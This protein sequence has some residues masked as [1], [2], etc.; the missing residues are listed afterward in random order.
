MLKAAANLNQQWSALIVEELTRQGI[1]TF[2]I[3]PGSRST[4]LTF[5]AAENPRANTHIIF[6]ER[7][8]AFFALGYARATALPAVLI[9]TSGTAAANYFPAVI[10]ASSENLPLIILSADRPPELK[11]SAANQTIDQTKLF[12]GYARWFFEM[13][14]PDEKIEATFVLSTINYALQK[15]LGQNAGPV[16]LNC[17]FREPL[18]PEPQP[19]DPDYLSPLQEWSKSNGPFTEITTGTP[20]TSLS[21]KPMSEIDLGNSIILC[22]RVNQDEA[23]AITKLASDFNLPVIADITCPIRLD[24]TCSNLIAHFDQLLLNDDFAGRLAGKTVLHFGGAFVSKR[25]LRWLDTYIKQYIHISPR[26]KRVDPLHKVTWRV[27][28]DIAAFCKSL[29]RVKAQPA[30]DW[31]WMKQLN[32]HIAAKIVAG[33]DDGLNEASAA[34]SLSRF[35]AGKALFMASSMPVRDLDMY[36]RPVEPAPIVAANRGASGIDGTVASAAGFAQGTGKPLMLLIGDLALL[37]D[38]SSLQL[39]KTLNQP[40]KVVVINNHGGG[41]FHFLPVAKHTAIFEPFFGTPHSLNFEHAADMFGLQYARPAS[42]KELATL[43]KNES[44]HLLIEIESERIANL[45]HHQTLQ[46]KLS[47]EITGWL[48]QNMA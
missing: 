45:E 1:N 29:T 10:E 2:V 32:D 5:A 25:V 6:D 48:K 35:C 4:P 9:C 8:A 12:G 38:L 11:D 14:C 41:I 27:T 33:L 17:M 31:R 22:G 26:E 44:G 36:A 40:A 37:H 21:G 43:L 47:E 28:S 23:A 46:H 13:P 42:L 18:A 19:F 3:S 15:A 30:W 20:V 16:H 34:L 7:A 24:G 39:I